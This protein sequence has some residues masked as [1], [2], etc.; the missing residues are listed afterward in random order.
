MKE[1]KKAE[2]E[3]EPEEESKN[4]ISRRDFLKYGVGVAAVAAGAT[5]LMG[6]IPLPAEQPKTPSTSNSSE[7][8]VVAVNSD[9]LTV[10]SGHNEVK[11]KDPG[12]A[13]EIASK[14]Q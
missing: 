5:A 11:L 2:R 9:Q 12:L 1:D 8:I 3:L 4:R 14:I 7:P 10:M 6:K 13:A